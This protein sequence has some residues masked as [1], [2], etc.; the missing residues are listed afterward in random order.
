MPPTTTTPEKTAQR[1]FSRKVAHLEAPE[2]SGT[3]A[4]GSSE[5]R[6]GLPYEELESL[7][8]ALGLT[9]EVLTRVLDV[10]ERTLQRRRQSGRLSPSESDRLWRIAHVYRSAVEAFD[11]RTEEAQAW[12][13]TPK[14]ALGGDTPVEH[15]DT[16]P[17]ERAVEQMLATIEHTMPA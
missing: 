15:L 12:L 3:A 17:G 6:Q 14:R 9:Q 1:A 4:V 5:V 2:V 7:S 13:T 8:Q 11:G 10:S 16:E